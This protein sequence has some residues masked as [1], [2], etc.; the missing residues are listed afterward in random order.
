MWGLGIGFRGYDG[1]NT[2]PRTSF[3]R[4]LHGMV[5][6]FPLTQAVGPEDGVLLASLPFLGDN[7]LLGGV[8]MSH[9]RCHDISGQG[10]LIKTYTPG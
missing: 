1:G 9:G 8:E 10:A 5:D 6:V 2:E 7:A 3:I 4:V